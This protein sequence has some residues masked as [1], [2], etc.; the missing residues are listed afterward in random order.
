[1]PLILVP[2]NSKI[3]A[4]SAHKVYLSIVDINQAAVTGQFPTVAIRR[5]SDG[6]FFN[7]TAF[8]DTTGTPTILN[9]PEIGAT[10]APGLYV[11]SF[12]DPGLLGALTKDRYQFA[13]SNAGTPTGT[14][15]EVLV[16]DKALR[17]INT[18]GL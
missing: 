17:D 12:T 9:M 10:S 5:E 2:T 6:F 13:Y 16:V 1:M 4:G 15:W 8:I 11:Y 3:L 14:A 7:G 18:Q